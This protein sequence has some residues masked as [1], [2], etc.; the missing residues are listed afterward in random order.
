MF[1]DNV[2]HEFRTPLTVIKEYASLV[3]DGVVGPVSAEQ[4]QMLTVVEDRAD[5]MNTMVEDMLTVSALEA[6]LLAV[7][8]KNCWVKDIVAYVRPGTRAQGRRQRRAARGRYRSASAGRFLR[9]GESRPRPHQSH[10]QRHQ[11]LRPTRPRPAQ[12]PT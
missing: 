5:D 2:S 12:L 11:V 7:Y 8:R 9:S 10:Y 4:K 6:G 3:K 1:V